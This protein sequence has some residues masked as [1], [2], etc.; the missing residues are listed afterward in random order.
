VNQFNTVMSKEFQQGYQDFLKG[1]GQIATVEGIKGQQAMSALSRV[2]TREEFDKQ[3]AIIRASIKA[4]IENAKTKAG[5]AGPQGAPA[6]QAAPAPQQSQ[7]QVGQRR[8]MKNGGWA[9]WDGIGW[10]PE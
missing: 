7:Y 5:M 9:V 10:K 3:I 6:P 4:G 1:T 8:Q 2:S